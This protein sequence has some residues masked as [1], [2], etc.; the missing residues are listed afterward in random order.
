MSLF[1]SIL[2]GIVVLQISLVFI[3][4]YYQIVQQA[5][6]RGWDHLWAEREVSQLNKQIIDHVQRTIHC[7]GSSSSSDYGDSIPKSC[8]AQ[9]TSACTA[10]TSYKSGCATQIKSVVE[11][12]EWW[13]VYA[14]FAMSIIEVTSEFSLK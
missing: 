14:T 3:V 7:C 5:S 2:L 9:E 8:C 13:I 12:S 6:S 4:F 11:N 10:A 1:S